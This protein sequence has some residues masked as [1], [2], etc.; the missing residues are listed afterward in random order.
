VDLTFDALADVLLKGRIARIAPQA[1]MG[2]GGTNYTTL[3]DF[4][5]GTLPPTLRWGMTAFVN[6]TVAE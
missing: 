4:D 3:I 6:I 5:D 2:Q 1:T